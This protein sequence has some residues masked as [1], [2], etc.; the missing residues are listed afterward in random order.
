MR[1][2]GKLCP[3]QNTIFYIQLPASNFERENVK[4]ISSSK[5]AHNK[6]R[7]ENFSDMCAL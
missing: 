4:N 7:F 6:A 2:I 1:E 5:N 3:V